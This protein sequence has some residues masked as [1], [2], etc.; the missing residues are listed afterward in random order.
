[1]TGF[2]HDRDKG[3]TLIEMLIAIMMAGIIMASLTAVLMMTLKTTVGLASNATSF[4]KQNAS[5][6]TEQVAVNNDLQDVARA[7]PSDVANVNALTNVDTTPG[8][9]GSAAFPCARPAADPAETGD[10]PIVNVAFKDNAGTQ[11]YVA[12][13]WSYDANKIRGQ[14]TR[15]DCTGTT[16]APK[17]VA[18]GLS[19]TSTPTIAALCSTSTNPGSGAVVG[20]CASPVGYRL[21]VRTLV[22]RDVGFDGTFRS[23]NSNASAIGGA[24]PAL[25]SP[26]PDQIVMTDAN[27]D[28][29][30]DTVTLTYPVK[31]A[32]LCAS[33]T[34]FTVASTPSGSTAGTP[35]VS[36]YTMT[37]PLLAPTG[38]RDTAASAFVLSFAPPASCTLGTFSTL[39]PIDS[40][41]PL[42]I[43]IQAVNPG[44]TDGKPDPGDAFTL[45]FSEP[46]NPSNIPSTVRVLLQNDG[47]KDRLYV[48]AVTAGTDLTPASGVDLGTNGQYIA[49]GG[50]ASYQAGVTLDNPT[51]PTTLTISIPTTA[52]CD[53]GNCSSLQANAGSGFVFAPNPGLHDQAAQQNPA[54]PLTLNPVPGAAT[55]TKVF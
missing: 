8:N 13:R 29:Y 54:A 10:T 48:S 11:H 43:G 32:L 36:G 47:T 53:L 37:L 15:Y 22:G 1:M 25:T 34:A 26:L 12:Y 4:G 46:L 16:A 5:N 20:S 7:F 27:G 51:A 17:V 14:L 45:R 40:A 33:P 24:T 39:A 42:L 28:G 19:S 50:T 18:R 30:I 55:I 49:L 9:W 3:F 2:E 23:L 52:S 21:T 44:A 6:V 38:Q 41:A 35:V 31:P